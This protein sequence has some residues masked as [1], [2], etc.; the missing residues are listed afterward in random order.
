VRTSDRSEQSGRSVLAAN[1][2]TDHL[3]GLTEGKTEARALKS[4]VLSLQAPA[5]Y[6]VTD[7]HQTRGRPLVDVVEAALRGGARLVQLRE[8]DL[9]TRALVAL[10]TDLRSVTKRHGAA[11]LI[12]DRIDVVI[13]VDADGVHLP[14]N[15][16]SI[17]DAR[18][19]L[20]PQRLIG[21][22]THSSAEAA[23]AGKAG[24][25]FVV[26]GPVFE[27][28]SKQVYGP[29]T[30]LDRLAETV[31]ATDVPVLA[32]GGVTQER[33]EETLA[34]GAAGVAVIRAVLEADDP[35]EAARS[36]LISHRQGSRPG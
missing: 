35:A 24:A 13:A 29:P 26:F 23:A 2:T 34:C 16:F 33:I 11:L 14:A 21:A 9:P 27:T 8:K 31:K 4:P 28:P 20:G 3:Q 1:V 25:D 5:L 12:N 30:G 32:I 7:R 18:Q 36:C 19:L 6:L 22:S 10:A 15:S 17:E